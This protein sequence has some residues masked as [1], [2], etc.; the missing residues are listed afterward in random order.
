MSKQS[1]FIGHDGSMTS[2]RT[3]PKKG[4][5]FRKLGQTS[6]DR[7]SDIKFDEGRQQFYITFLNYPSPNRT[8][9]V[10][11]NVIYGPYRHTMDLNCPN[12]YDSPI[13]YFEEYEQAVEHEIELINE[14][15]RKYGKDYI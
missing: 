3:S 8:Q 4:V 12:G 7:V 2:L 6:V 10:S 1:I 13:H 9:V 14:L 5:D 15:R 11:R